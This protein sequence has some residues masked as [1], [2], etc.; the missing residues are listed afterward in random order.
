MEYI[1]LG[2]LALFILLTIDG[3]LIQKRNEKIGDHFDCYCCDY[4]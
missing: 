1:L 4:D 2:A 3:I